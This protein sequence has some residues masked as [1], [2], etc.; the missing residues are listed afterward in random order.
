MPNN[1]DEKTTLSSKRH[2]LLSCLLPPYANA[3]EEH[4]L[5]MSVIEE[6]Q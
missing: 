6:I 3:G 5:W 2:I 1:Y 4:A